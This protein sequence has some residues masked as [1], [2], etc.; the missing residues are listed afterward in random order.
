MS[1]RSIIAAQFDKH[2]EAGGGAAVCAGD[3]AIR[4][5]QAYEAECAR[6]LTGVKTTV[7]AARLCR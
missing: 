1:V 7:R 5:A 2:C 3:A 4:A 6:P